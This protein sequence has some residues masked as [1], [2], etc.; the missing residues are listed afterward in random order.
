MP[1]QYTAMMAI[2]AGLGLSAGCGSSDSTEET[3]Q[4][5]STL[6]LDPTLTLLGTYKN[7]GG[8]IEISAYDSFTRRLF[9]VNSTS[10]IP[11]I[12]VIDIANPAAPALLA[13]IP[14]PT[15]GTP[16]SV[17]VHRGLIASAF[18]AANRQE[19]GTV[20]FY[21]TATLT[22]VGSV[23]VGA[24]PDMVT[25]TKQGNQLL[26]AN[27]GEPAPNY[28]SDPEGSVSII[29]IKNDHGTWTFQ[30]T[31]VRFLPA[32]PLLHA[33]SIRIFGGGIFGTFV[34]PLSTAAQDFEPEYIT[35]SE[36]GK[37]AWVTL[38]ENNAIA[39]VDITKR[40][41]TKVIGLGWK[42]H[43]LPGNGL[44][45]S[46]RDGPA[47]T[48]LVGNIQN[49]P[50]KGMYQPDSID[51]FKAKGQTYLVTANEG[52]AREWGAYT[53]EARIRDLVTAGRIRTDHPVVTSGAGA[54]NQRLGRLTVTTK[55]VPLTPDGKLED[56]FA[57]GARSF[58][59]LDTDGNV[60]F[61]SGDQIEKKISEL[62]PGFQNSDLTA[63]PGPDTRSDNKGPEPE[64]LAIAEIDGRSYAFVGLERIGGVMM[65]DL[66]NPAAPRFITYVNNR[67]FT[68]PATPG[69][70]GPEG[71]L[72]I[73]SCDSPT[74]KPILVISNEISGTATFYEISG[75]RC[76]YSGEDN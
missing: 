21:D 48:P 35:V 40:L 27:E 1:N 47:G 46:D 44:D 71:L 43:S 23:T 72:V 65:Y 26:V 49:W 31:I 36:D 75:G 30:G 50:I 32:T 9:S 59:V 51:H 53:E 14:T 5:T 73:K 8:A 66:T 11:R 12:E 67:H 16:N 7:A 18:E 52:D 39:V 70:L 45:A 34:T 33:D 10:A 68:T 17:A 61:D 69:D 37:T 15:G 28:A 29:D 20:K 64:G 57:F 2:L 3:A 13:T 6:K 55:G 42:D 76:T 25:F 60:V 54:D 74:G 58:S 56:V 24:V 22:E 62:L 63:S 41:F 19:P 4:N 38:Q